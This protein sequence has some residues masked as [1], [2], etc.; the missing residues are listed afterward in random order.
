MLRR[1][2]KEAEYEELNDHG[3]TAE[4]VSTDLLVPGDIMEIPSHGCVM[5]CDAILLTGNCILNEAMLT[6]IFRFS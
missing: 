4:V 6:G 5:H 2:P 3:Y 1:S